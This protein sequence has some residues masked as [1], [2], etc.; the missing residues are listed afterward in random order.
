MTYVEQRE[1]YFGCSLYVKKDV[2]TRETRMYVKNRAN[3]IY[4]KFVSIISV[5]NPTEDFV[6]IR[7]VLTDYSG[8]TLA[9]V[10]T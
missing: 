9:Y 7:L 10:S 3:L 6:P 1:I 5:S 8:A 2:V 4:A